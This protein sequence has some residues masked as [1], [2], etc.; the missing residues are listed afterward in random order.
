MLI[1]MDLVLE[2]IFH[3]Q[4]RKRPYPL[5]NSTY[6]LRIL[7]VQSMLR[8]KYTKYWT[9]KF[10]KSLLCRLCWDQIE[11]GMKTICPKTLSFTWM[12]SKTLWSLETIFCTWMKTMISIL[13]IWIGGVTINASMCLHFDV[14]CVKSWFKM[15]LKRTHLLW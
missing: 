10:Q 11:P 9:W 14:K 3:T 1:F 2:R 13:N 5:T 15:V 4:T 7:N 8:K 12:N 6:R